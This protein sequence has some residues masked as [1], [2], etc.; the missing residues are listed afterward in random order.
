MQSN[1]E[2][3]I[4]LINQIANWVEWRRREKNVV[5][6]IVCGNYEIMISNY[7]EIL[8]QQINSFVCLRRWK[9]LNTLWS[10]STKIFSSHSLDVLLI[11]ALSTCHRIFS[12]RKPTENRKAKSNIIRDK[13]EKNEIKIVSHFYSYFFLCV[14]NIKTK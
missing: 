11:R 8:L 5:I 7:K 1:A 6:G 14:F 10:L 9:F 2:K 3:R 13:K 4:I 12:H